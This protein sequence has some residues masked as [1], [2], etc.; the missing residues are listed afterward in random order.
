[1]FTTHP[2]PKTF[3]SAAYGDGWVNY[4]EEQWGK[5]HDAHE[6]RMQRL[7]RQIGNKRF[8]KIDLTSLG[9]KGKDETMWNA[10]GNFLQVDVSNAPKKFPHR[11]V[12]QYSAID[13]PKRQM[14][15]L[16]HRIV[17]RKWVL[18]LLWIFV[19]VGRFF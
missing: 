12:F 10:I 19:Y 17:S 8:L 9:K 11:F 13:Q 2:T 1:M 14:K 7:K 6:K 18:L 3:Y 4:D 5:I 16:L 15:Y